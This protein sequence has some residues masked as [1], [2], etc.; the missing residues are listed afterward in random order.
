MDKDD[1]E[2]CTWGEVEEPENKVEG[3]DERLPIPK[4]YK[5]TEG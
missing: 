1:H 2:K 4:V 5:P 3:R